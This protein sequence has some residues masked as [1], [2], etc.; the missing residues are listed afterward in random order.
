MIAEIL[1]KVYTAPHYYAVIS[2]AGLFFAESPEE[3]DLMEDDPHEALVRLF[4]SK[5]AADVYCGYVNVLHGDMKVTEVS[6]K[7]VWYLLDDIESLCQAQ[8]NC[9]AR[10]AFCVLDKDDWP[11]DIDTIHSAFILPN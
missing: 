10:I 4:I 3:Q 11:V 2:P 5:E 6:L 9:P 7:D 8:F 1:T